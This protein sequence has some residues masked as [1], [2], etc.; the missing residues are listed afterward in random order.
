MS[1]IRNAHALDLECW[2]VLDNV[3]V[4]RS[5]NECSQLGNS[6]QGVE[7]LRQLNVR[8]WPI[9]QRQTKALMIALLGLKSISAVYFHRNWSSL[10]VGI[11]IVRAKCSM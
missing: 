11:R 10:L 1:V 5:G 9:L 8:E 7:K 2:E 4:S 6:V 3:F